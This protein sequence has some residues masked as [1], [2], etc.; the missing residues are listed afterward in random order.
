MHSRLRAALLLGAA[1]VSVAHDARATCVGL[2]PNLAGCASFPTAPPAWH[3]GTA[4]PASAFGNAGDAYVVQGTGEVWTE[5]SSGPSDTGRALKPSPACAGG[6][7]NF[8]AVAVPPSASVGS[9]GDVDIDPTSGAAYAK[10]SGTWAPTGI[11]MVT[12]EGW[13]PSSINLGTVP[14]LSL[15]CGGVSDLASSTTATSDTTDILVITERL[16]PVLF[17]T[18]VTHL[19]GTL[20]QGSGWDL[21]LSGPSLIFGDVTS[22]G[23]YE[24]ATIAYASL[25]AGGGES[26]YVCAVVNKSSAAVTQCGMAVP[27]GDMAFARSS[28]G[29]AWDEVGTAVS[30]LSAGAISAASGQ[31]YVGNFEASDSYLGVLSSLEITDGT[32]V[33]ANPTISSYA[34]GAASIGDSSVSGLNWTLTNVAAGG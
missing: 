3:G 6:A 16:T 10:V 12:G 11:T 2:S 26:I 20:P 32:A 14:G 34:A 19:V 13:P 17:G 31:L 30:G 7:E 4:A 33:L 25:P 8:Y 15:A 18:G 21:F 5:G 27:S 22:S 24:S 1:A 28:N 29:T 9:N 23:S